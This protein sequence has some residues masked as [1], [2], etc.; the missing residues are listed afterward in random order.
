MSSSLPTSSPPPISDMRM[1]DAKEPST[2]VNDACEHCIMN[3]STEENIT[4]ASS[5][6]STDIT[7]HF[8]QVE[9]LTCLWILFALI[10]IGNGNY[11]IMKDL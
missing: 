8:Y 10:V 9:T 5:K 2:E 4:N 6:T 3:I 7:E 11:G 1:D